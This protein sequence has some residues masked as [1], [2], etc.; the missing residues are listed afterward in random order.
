MAEPANSP[1]IVSARPLLSHRGAERP[2]LSDAVLS[3]DVSLPMDGR[4]NAEIRL[5]NW[6]RRAGEADFQWQDIA[7]GDDFSIAFLDSGRQVFAGQVTALEER[8]GQGAPMLVLLVEDPLH[9]LA[10]ARRSR[11]WEEQGIDDV[12]AS[13]AAEHGLSADVSVSSTS[14]DWYQQNETDLNFIARLCRRHD[15]PLRIH[16]GGLLA[17]PPETDPAPVAVSPRSNADEIRIIADLSHQVT[18]S[19]LRG[20][21]FASADRVEHET[22]RLQPPASGE[23]A[24]DLLGSL[25]WG[26][27]EWLGGAS[28]RGAAEAR[29]RAVAALHRQATR[30]L[31]GEILLRGDPALAAGG[32]IELDGVSPRL[33]GRYRVTRL[34]H[35]F[36]GDNGFVSHLRVERSDWS[37]AR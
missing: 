35:R 22:E 18:G 34:H 5:L 24:A 21:D 20:W 14:A 3:L 27:G 15:V 37:P 8:Y 30:F 4:G 2:E 25:G 13:I 17:R 10:K 6:G 23:T 7:L 9:R 36:D 16:D 28:A 19:G 1:S 33:R 29:D 11:A 32:E 12:I 31:T 26:G